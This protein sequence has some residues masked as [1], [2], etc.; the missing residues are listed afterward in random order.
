MITLEKHKR[1]KLFLSTIA[2][3]FS[4]AIVILIGPDRLKNY[5]DMDQ[6]YQSGSCISLLMLIGGIIGFISAFFRKAVLFVLSNICYMM[7]LFLCRGG[8]ESYFSY[9]LLIATGFVAL[10]SIYYDISFDLGRRQERKEIIKDVYTEIPELSNDRYTLRAIDDM[11]DASDLFEVYSDAKAVAFFNT[12]LGNGDDF[13]YETMEAM[14]HA[15]DAWAYAYEQKYMVR[16]AVVD[17]YTGSTI[18]T[19]GL[20]KRES[21]DSFHNCALLYLDVR[22]D[23]ETSE[24]L[25]SILYIILPK[26]RLLFACDKVAVKAI[27]DATERI[28]AL[29]YRGFELSEEPLRGADGV[30]YFSYYVKQI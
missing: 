4:I 25:G 27:P 16:W 30:E 24:S 10:A 3:L 14:F 15:L 9:F 26:I 29:E 22:S 28:A 1:S 23:Y 18:G 2:V 5:A 19:I 7:S 6:I 17:K 13:H 8:K 12:D 11:K 20:S 21:E